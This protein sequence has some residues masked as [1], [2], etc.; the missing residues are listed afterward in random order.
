MPAYTE[1][2]LKYFRDRKD[3]FN[4]HQFTN[5]WFPVDNWPLF[6]GTVNMARF[7]S[8]YELMKK[9]IDLPGHFCE[10][11]CWNG[12]NLVFM[13]KVLQILRP[14]DY[15]RVIGFDWFE[16]L[17]NAQGKNDVKVDTKEAYNYRGDV[18]LLKDILW[19]Y[20]L[21]D[22]VRIINGN[23]LDTLPAFLEEWQDLRFSFIYFDAD[24]YEP[25]KLGIELLWPKL[26]NGGIMV[27]DEYNDLDFPG[28]TAAVHE[29]LGENVKL[30][31]ILFTRQP[32]AYLVK[33]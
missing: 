25:T 6:A 22:S 19:L 31:S 2:D 12:T 10:L 30:L 13:A 14:K 5:P 28:E 3:L 26:L 24:L 32:T 11:G 9:V 4:K 7:L 16:G 33:Q 23:I 1:S 27:F 17:E 20:D 8:I 18:G 21:Q 15:T 29:V